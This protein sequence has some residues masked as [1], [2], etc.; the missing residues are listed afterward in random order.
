MRWILFLLAGLA[1]L[2]GATTYLVAGP[3]S[4]VIFA[5]LFSG[6]AI[7]D[8]IVSLQ[9]E[10]RKITGPAEELEKMKDKIRTGS[11]QTIFNGG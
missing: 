3:S 2:G 9:Q 6:A 7:V 1:F 4:F 8:A 5:I 10:I 11:S